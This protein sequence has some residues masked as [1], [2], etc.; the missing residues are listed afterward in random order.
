MATR[1]IGKQ[2]SRKNTTREPQYWRRPLGRLSW[3]VAALLAFEVMSTASAGAA[4]LAVR[5][6]N[7]RSADGIVHFAVYDKAERFPSDGDWI[8][9]A[10]VAAG[11]EGAL[12]VF[13]LPKP[14]TYAVA[15]FHDENGNGKFDKFLSALPVEGYGFSS[16]APVLLGPPSFEDAVVRVS[17]AGTDVII[18]MRY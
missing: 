8:E 9:G 14:G 15:V 4:E 13:R 5:V 7:L 16:N 12:A 6:T 3:L 2:M 11:S 17:P 1:A 10:K 18:R